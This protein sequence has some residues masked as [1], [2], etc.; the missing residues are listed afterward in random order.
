MLSA[1]AINIH[2]PIYTILNGVGVHV[3]PNPVVRQVAPALLV[4]KVLTDC[5][6]MAGDWRHASGMKTQALVFYALE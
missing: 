5:G 2:V 4:E 1:S 6:A 3:Y